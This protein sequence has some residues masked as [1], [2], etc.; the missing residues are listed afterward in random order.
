MAFWWWAAL[1]AAAVAVI[2]AIASPVRIR[3]RYS[4]SGKLDQL[5]VIVKALYGLVRFRAVVPAILIRGQK[6]L[7]RRETTMQV[8]G[9]PNR[10]AA[11]IPLGIEALRNKWQGYRGVLEATRG[12]REWMGR[13]LKKV[14]CTRFRLDLRIGTG[15]APSTAIISGLLWSL[16][17]AAIAFAGRTFT[18]RTRPHGAVEPVYNRS[19]FSVVWEADFRV[20]LGTV[21]WSMIGLGTRVVR[22]RPAIRSW[23]RWLANPKSAGAT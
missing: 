8:A 13:T 6:V 11:D 19:E 16:Y 22:L 9:Q 2:A 14:E 3:V 1:C 18:L 4:K 21:I 15:D 20:R 17:G 7:I 12:F 10:G 23:K 5:I